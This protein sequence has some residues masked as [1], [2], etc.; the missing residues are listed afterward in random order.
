MARRH[1]RT[2]VAVLALAATV[3][4]VGCTGAGDPSSSAAAQP[5]ALI[6]AAPGELD[7]GPYRRT[8]LDIDA[9][10]VPNAAA[11]SY[12]E[13]Q[14][15]AEAVVLPVEVDAELVT[16]S[17]RDTYSIPDGK[18]LSFALTGQIDEAIPAIAEKYGYYAG[19]TTR[20]RTDLGF[21]VGTR[22]IMTHA[23]L[24]FPDAESAVHA[25]ADLHRDSLTRSS[26]IIPDLPPPT[27]YPMVSLPDSFVG[28]KTG[29]SYVIGSS[30]TPYDCY[31]IHTELDA[32]AFPGATIDPWSWVETTMATTLDLQRTLLDGFH[33]T[34]PADLTALEVD[35]DGV[36]RLT[37]PYGRDDSGDFNAMS[38][39]GVRG[40]AHLAA[41][42]AGT[43]D[44]LTATGTDHFAV[45]ATNIYRSETVGGAEELLGTMPDLLRAR[46]SSI[47][48]PGPPGVPN[49]LCFEIVDALTE[50]VTCA[51][52]HG[53]YVAEVSG[54]TGKQAHQLATAQYLIFEGDAAGG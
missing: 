28:V 33:P 38:V 7:P 34:D 1:A 48:V 32:M 3:A 50:H 17:A 20:R 27:E 14:R 15:L 19:F 9:P 13:S 6:P 16:P 45:N 4:V 24:Q 40:A 5:Q 51:V 25:A 12:R 49:S 11:G 23:V 36:L 53:P 41:D 44:A 46:G 42:Q 22:R 8:P 29:D 2:T 37:V 26:V 30:F 10:V 52:Q 31:V 43:L 47:E 18:I 39:F 35:P 21:E 54:D